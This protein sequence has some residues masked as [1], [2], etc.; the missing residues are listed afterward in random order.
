MSNL[1]N[2]FQKSFKKVLNL[3]SLVL[4]QR[5]FIRVQSLYSI[6][7]NK[8][9]QKSKVSTLKSLALRVIKGKGK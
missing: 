5:S 7:L 6:V 3:F 8:S 9:V 4:N 2:H 1:K